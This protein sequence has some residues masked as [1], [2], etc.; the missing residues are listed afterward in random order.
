MRDLIDGSIWSECV[1]VRFSLDELCKTHKL[2]KESKDTWKN[3]PSQHFFQAARRFF[4]VLLSN[5]RDIDLIM[6]C[7]EKF[8][9]LNCKSDVIP[10]AD[11][12]CHDVMNNFLLL[13]DSADE[14]GRDC[15]DS[16]ERSEIV[17]VNIVA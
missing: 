7:A 3:I 1:F 5:V 4:F 6:G 11:T 14:T 2:A 13:S 17:H 15:L 10:A 9:F 16:N 8:K 12:L